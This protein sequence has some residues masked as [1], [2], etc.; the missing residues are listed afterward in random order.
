MTSEITPIFVMG[1]PRSGTTFL[2]SSIA[3]HKNVVVLP[4]LHFLFDMMEE[5]IVFGPLSTE[6]KVHQLKNDFHFC[7][8]GLF[9]TLDQLL[10]FVE[11]KDIKTLV[12]EIVRKYNQKHLRKGY[13]HWVEHSPHSH[14]YIH[15]IKY[16]FPNAVF[17]HSLRDPRAVYVSTVSRP[18]GFKDVVSGANNWR[19]IV[20]DI[21]VKEK[22]FNILSVKYEDVVDMIEPSLRRISDHLGL[23]FDSKMLSNDGLVIHEYLEDSRPFTNIEADSSRKERWRQSITTKELEHINFV[24]WRLM[25]KFGYS[26][27]NDKRREITG[28]ERYFK[29]VLGTLKQKYTNRKFRK[30]VR[31][32][33][34]RLN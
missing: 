22:Y 24:C 8:L 9:E 26:S 17:V 4:E 27:V 30:E 29:R 28:L 20:T 12:L 33:F 6:R 10:S 21:L 2:A 13:T 34:C 11:G 1:A 7:S 31:D 15:I 5:E 16:Y 23:S 14:R 18:W 25:E 32:E 19:D 3:G